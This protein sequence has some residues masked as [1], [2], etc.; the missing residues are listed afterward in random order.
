[1]L[2]I[3]IFNTNSNEDVLKKL[4][5]KKND[6]FAPIA[7]EYSIFED[8]I[9]IVGSTIWAGDLAKHELSLLT[10]HNIVFSASQETFANGKAVYDVFETYKATLQFI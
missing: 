9:G 6:V 5:Q 7:N 1:M 3:I 2:E 4:F 8:R 10:R